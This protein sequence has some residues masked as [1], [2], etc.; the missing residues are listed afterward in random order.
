MPCIFPTHTLNVMDTKS[1]HT[2]DIEIYLVERL[3][4]PKHNIT[5]H[6]RIPLQT[7]GHFA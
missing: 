6:Q 2:W 5:A 4:K 3:I 1:P 7:L